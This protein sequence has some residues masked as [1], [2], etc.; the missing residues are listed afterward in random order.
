[1]SESRDELMKDVDEEHRC[2][3][4]YLCLWVHDADALLVDHDPD[5][6]RPTGLE[7]LLQWGMWTES[8]AAHSQFQEYLF[9]P[10]TYFNI[11]EGAAK[12][13]P[14]CNGFQ[15]HG[16]GLLHCD[17]ALLVVGVDDVLQDEG[18]KKVKCTLERV[19]V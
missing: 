8:Q 6:V 13:W 9:G 11:K 4:P 17:S 18:E 10:M 2:R 1:M 3:P 7:C 5:L 19:H 12:R 14:C 15:E 16:F